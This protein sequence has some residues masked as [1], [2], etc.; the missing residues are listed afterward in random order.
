MITVTEL[1]VYKDVPGIDGYIIQARLEDPTK[2]F[3]KIYR[4]ASS[5]DLSEIV[6]DFVNVVLSEAENNL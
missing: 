5:D 2:E 4:I 1:K 3:D 6:R